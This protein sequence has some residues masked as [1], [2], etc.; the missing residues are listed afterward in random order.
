MCFIVCIDFLLSRVIATN[1]AESWFDCGQYC[2]DEKLCVGFNF[3]DRSIDSKGNCE[4]T[5]ELQQ[6]QSA[7]VNKNSN[8]NYYQ[9]I[10]QVRVNFM[11][12][13]VCLHEPYVRAW[14][15]V[16]SSV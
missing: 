11:S 8:W 5:D 16:L 7:K 10:F 6:N 12:L 4:L 14:F 1:R 3:N 2:I 9:S 15:C 13:T